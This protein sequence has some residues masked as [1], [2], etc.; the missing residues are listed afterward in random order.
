M[1]QGF[2][3]T[4]P[5]ALFARA[6]WIRQGHLF[7]NNYIRVSYIKYKAQIASISYNGLYGIISFIGQDLSR[8]SFD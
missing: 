3:V 7:L 6:F 1:M 4:V 5:L 8:F 2:L